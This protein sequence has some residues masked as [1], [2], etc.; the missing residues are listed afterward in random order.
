MREKAFKNT[1]FVASRRIK[2][3][4]TSLPVDAHRSNPSLL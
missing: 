1:N 3:E 2:R 4:N